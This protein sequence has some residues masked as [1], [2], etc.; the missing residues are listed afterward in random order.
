[1]SRRELSPR[2]R[3]IARGL[4]VIVAVGL[5]GTAAYLIAFGSSNKQIQLGVIAGFW[6]ALLG[7]VSIYGVGHHR[8]AADSAG[9]ELA[10]RTIGQVESLSDRDA[11]HAYDSQLQEMVARELA[12]IQRAMDDQVAQLR[13]EVATLRGDIVDKLGG[14]L[15]LERIETTRLMGSDIEALQHEV[16][17]LAFARESL[18]AERA[19]A[20]SDARQLFVADMTDLADIAPAAD[21]VAEVAEVAEVAGVPEV[22]EVAAPSEPVSAPADPTPHFF[23]TQPTV[24]IVT[25]S[26]PAAP[27][28]VAHPPAAPVDDPFAQMP[29]LSAFHEPVAAVPDPALA[30]AGAHSAGVAVGRAPVHGSHSHAADEEPQPTPTRSGGRRRRADGDGNDILARLLA[31]NRSG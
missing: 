21:T 1:M 3:A 9:T 20:A 2:T 14:Q 6:S 28:A 30:E 15:R 29:R 17:R 19:S 23:P 8:G 11:R 27:V 5:A 10:I 4:G 18:A 12:K 24:P 22:A 16:R 13:A 7:A 26:E 25:V 31:E